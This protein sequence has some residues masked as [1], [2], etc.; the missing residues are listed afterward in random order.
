[1]KLEGEQK[2][3]RNEMMAVISELLS[4]LNSKKVSLVD[5]EAIAYL[6][7]K[8]VEEKSATQLDHY[9]KTGTFRIEAEGG[10]EDEK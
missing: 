9:K 3:D 2:V 1:V 5:A 8:E 7:H 4:V 10:A 6:F